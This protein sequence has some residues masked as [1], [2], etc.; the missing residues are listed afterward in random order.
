MDF[1][2]KAYYFNTKIVEWEPMVEPW[3][4]STSLVMYPNALNIQFL[5]KQ[6]LNINLTHAMIKSI[7]KSLELIQDE[8][9]KIKDQFG[10][11]AD[12]QE[13]MLS[14][15][16]TT[17]THF[18]ENCTELEVHVML[19]K[20]S[21][22][23]QSQMEEKKEPL[24]KENLRIFPGTT[25]DFNPPPPSETHSVL[26]EWYFGQE[27]ESIVITDYNTISDN[28]HWIKKHGMWLCFALSF[29]RFIIQMS[30][31]HKY[32]YKYKYKYR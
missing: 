31:K 28:L 18:I 6:V 22:A 2:L 32:K 21:D 3:S 12:K 16:L 19:W 23:V 4:A 24:L 15:M 26:M 25:T 10:Q 1:E 14:S 11:L 30:C 8:E 5:P 13:A 17:S 29:W 9:N 20:G 7:Q 27:W